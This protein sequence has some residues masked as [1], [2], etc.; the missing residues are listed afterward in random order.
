MKT[1]PT[2]KQEVVAEAGHYKITRLLYANN[3][4]IPC[5]IESDYYYSFRR[6]EDNFG[7]VGSFCYHNGTLWVTICKRRY[8]R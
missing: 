1:T 4:Q 7:L 2:E 3:Y 8:L 6:I 5:R